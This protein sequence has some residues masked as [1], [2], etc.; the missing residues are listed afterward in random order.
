MFIANLAL[1]RHAK[2]LCAEQVNVTNLATK[3]ERNTR[4]DNDDI[5][6]GKCKK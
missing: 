4:R 3:A 6:C 1:H 5:D 2:T